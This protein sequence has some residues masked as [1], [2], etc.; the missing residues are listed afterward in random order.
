LTCTAQQTVQE[1]EFSGE[2]SY[3]SAKDKEISKRGIKQLKDHR[4]KYK[5]KLPQPT[6]EADSENSGYMLTTKNY[7]V[8]CYPGSF[9]S[10]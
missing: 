7:S 2:D 3:I 9:T 10:N 1:N 5:Q 8:H 6:R 4:L